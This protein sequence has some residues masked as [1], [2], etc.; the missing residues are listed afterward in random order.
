MKDRT[1]YE[2]QLVRD[3]DTCGGEAVFRGTRVLLRVVLADLADGA[4][5]QDILR[6][7]PALNEEHV[8]AAIAFA[9]AVAG[10]GGVPLFP[11]RKTMRRATYEDV[12]NAPEDEA[13]EI[14]PDTEP[15]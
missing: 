11:E 9:A 12:L 13:A 2:A 1:E 8:G 5:T 6:D 10:G 15:A 3:P 4:S 7:F 14:L